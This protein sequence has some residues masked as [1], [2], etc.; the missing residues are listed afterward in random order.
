MRAFADLYT[1]LDETT[2][3]NEKLDALVRYFSSAPPSDAAW[4]VYFLSGRRPRQVVPR[5][6]VREWANDMAGIS[7]WLFGECY[8]AVGDMAE[9]ITLLLPETGASD[10]RPLTYWVEERLLPLRVATEDEQRAS[11]TGAWREL[12]RTQRFVWNKLL[13]GAFRVGV[14]QRLI[15]RALASVGGVEDAIVAHRLM[16]S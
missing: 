7:E 6:K 3:T 15:T 1:A 8:D 5:N 4:V 14:S 13:T 9:T 10:D 2:R 16:G 12:D 11:V